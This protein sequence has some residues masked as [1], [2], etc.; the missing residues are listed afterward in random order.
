MCLRLVAGRA[1]WNDRCRADVEAASFNRVVKM[2]LG[3]GATA[4]AAL[5]TACGGPPATGADSC[6]DAL[7]QTAKPVAE[8]ENAWSV[9]GRANL[10]VETSST[11]SEPVRMTIDFDDRMALDIEVPGS[12]SECAHQPVHRYNF[13]LPA[14]QLTVSART[15]QGQ[16]EST[17]LRVGRAT[18]W[19]VVQ[20]QEGLPLQVET[21]D[22]RPQWG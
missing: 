13:H 6:A 16:R 8:P 11:L 14:G 10:V 1:L 19:I 20:V 21:W 17:Q 12:P 15:D 18:R 22:E 9:A 7:E 2:K 5:L 3:F 4:L